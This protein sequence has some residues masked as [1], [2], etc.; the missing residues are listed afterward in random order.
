MVPSSKQS[1]FV[2]LLAGGL[3]L[4]ISTNL[5]KLSAA[6]GTPPLAFLTWSVLGA[7]VVLLGVDAL[8][9]T[10][11]TIRGRTV[12]YFLV[13]GLVSVAASNLI[14]FAAVP[15]V[16]A[17]FVALAI[18]F[19]PLF[20]YLGSLALGLESLEWRRAAGVACALAGAGYIGL[21]KLDDPGASALWIGLTLLGPVLLAVGNVYRTVR[22]PRG[23]SAAA[24]A[25]GMLAAAGL[26]LLL[27]GA[28]SRTAGF[29]PATLSLGVDLDNGRAVALIAAQTASF[30]VQFL[31]LFKLQETGGPVY[32]SLL[33]A[34]GAVVGVPVAVLALG[35]Q[36][37]AG[38]VAGGLAIAAGVA[39]LS[40]GGAAPA[41][42]SESRTR[43]ATPTS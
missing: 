40:F 3:L 5:A 19:P 42:A 2:L 12:E 24:L 37:P 35:E 13:A 43:P 15:R 25:P 10:L 41:P 17:G 7:A 4:G 29:M 23:E 27:A 22:W 38:I 8:R 14:F 32:L 33:G 28:A 11:P 26:L 16:G 6:A 18:A 31:L 21:L 1:A 20:T 39:L 9:G 36:W 34:V 30:A